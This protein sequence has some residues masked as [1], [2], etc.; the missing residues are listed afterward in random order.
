MPHYLSSLMLVCTVGVIIKHS[1]YRSY[2]DMTHGLEQAF[3]FQCS[4]D[5]VRRPAIPLNSDPIAILEWWVVAVSRVDVIFFLFCLDS[6]VLFLCTFFRV[7]LYFFPLPF[8]V[9]HLSSATAHMSE[10]KL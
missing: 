4:D 3:L 1:H 10:R 2:G 8:T 5:Q 9:P 7:P 6:Y